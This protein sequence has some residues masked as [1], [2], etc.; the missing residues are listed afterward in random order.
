[1][2]SLSDM[3]EAIIKDMIDENHGFI[4]ITRG[5]LAQR[6]NCVPSQITYVLEKRFTNNQGY[7]VESRRG[8]GG[9]IRIQRVHLNDQDSNRLMHIV[10]SLDEELTQQELEI[11]L[12]NM[13]R[14]KILTNNDAQLI[15]ATANDKTLVPVPRMIRGVVRASILKNGLLQIIINKRRA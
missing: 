6:V 10:N 8:G 15:F 5:E 2:A 11:I 1:M 13:I 7:R 14:Y 3:I 4:E 12:N 9:W